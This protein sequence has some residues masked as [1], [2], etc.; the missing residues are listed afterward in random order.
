MNRPG[1]EGQRSSLRLIR[2]VVTVVAAGAVGRA[3][4]YSAVDAFLVYVFGDP[5]PERPLA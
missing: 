1:S 2:S 4:W 5:A 3:L